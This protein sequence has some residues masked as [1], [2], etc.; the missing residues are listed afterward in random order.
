MRVMAAVIVF[1]LIGLGTAAQQP[2]AAASD[3][4]ACVAMANQGNLKRWSKT[5]EWVWGKMCAVRRMEPG[6]KASSLPAPK[7]STDSERDET[8]IDLQCTSGSCPPDRELQPD[9]LI[10]ILTD[11]RLKPAI[12][13]WG[14]RLKHAVVTGKFDLSGMTIEHELWLDNS[15]FRG[16]VD[17]NAAL[18]RKELSLEGGVFEDGLN[19]SLARLERGISI[20]GGTRVKGNFSLEAA[21]IMGQINGEDLWVD[22]T[23][24]L[25]LA[26]IDGL[27]DLDRGKFST[28]SMIDLTV[29]QNLQLRRGTVTGS[30][31]L[32]QAS[33]GR[34]LL[35]NSAG[36][37][38]LNADSLSVGGVLNLNDA[39]LDCGGGPFC[40]VNLDRIRVKGPLESVGTQYCTKSAEGCEVRLTGATIDGDARLNGSRST[41]NIVIERSHFGRSLFLGES[42]QPVS[43]FDEAVVIRASRIAETLSL[44]GASVAVLDLSGSEILGELLFDLVKPANAQPNLGTVNLTDASAGQFHFRLKDWLPNGPA[45]IG[46]ERF[47]YGGLTGEAVKNME[48]LTTDYLKWLDATQGTSLPAYLKFA[49]YLKTAGVNDSAREVIYEGRKHQYH[50]EPY[51]WSKVGGTITFLTTG[52]GQFP[53]RSLWSIL[54]LVG[55]GAWVFRDTARKVKD[56]MCPVVYSFDTLIPLVRL[57]EDDNEV[58]PGKGWRRAYYY[59]HKT[60]GWI[61]AG[62]LGSALSNL[63]G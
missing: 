21:R 60:S 35:L 46:I 28:I 38:N 16:H 2:A 36:L 40:K 20:H 19:L 17:F 34:S 53:E 37:R 30:I 49:T 31:S 10:D 18:F 39:K 12:R 4:E 52:F 7:K 1:T 13:P 55:F 47:D 15:V 5:E 27:L 44:E 63:V 57:N 48:T 32:D 50:S 8:V 25:D 58:K 56:G 61:L 42:E 33:V 62:L 22:G 26:T 45:I 59:V 51:G 3:R 9:F 6:D 11:P 41:G 14:I 43:R 23:L 54:I 29:G 24:D